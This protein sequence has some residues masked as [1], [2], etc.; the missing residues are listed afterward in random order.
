MTNFSLKNPYTII[1]LSLLVA[2]LGIMAFFRTPTDLFPNSTPPQVVV[3]TVQ[4]GA[5]AANISHKTTEV[6]EKELNSI[7]GLKKIV[8]TSRDEVSVVNAEFY[9]YKPIGEAVVDVQNAVSRIESKLPVNIK[10]PSIYRITDTT[11]PLLTIALTPKK[12]SSKNLRDIRLLAENQ[13]MK[14]LLQIPGV[15]DVDIFGAN[16][17]EINICIKKSVLDANNLSIA[18]V[19]GVL[20]QYNIN[21]PSGNVYTTKNE[22]IVNSYDEFKNLKEIENIP[23]I[24]K[25]DGT[26]FLRDI[27]EVKLATVEA[28]S[29][30]HGNGKTAIAITVMRLSTV[31][32]VSTIKRVKKNLKALKKKY[33]DIDFAITTDQS[34]VIDAN[35]RGMRSSLLQAILLTALVIFIF[36]A[37][38]RA[39]IVISISIPMAFLASLMILW[40]SPFTLNMVTLSGLIISVGMVVDASIVVLEN[41]FRHYREMKTPD[42]VIA[43]KNGVNEVKLSITAGMLTTVIVLM[44]VM[45]T[46]GYTQQLMRPLNLMICSTLVAA[47]LAALTIVP[48]LIAK[49]LAKPKHKKNFLERIFSYTDVGIACLSDTYTWILTKAL[50][51]RFVT[52]GIAIAIFVISMKIVPPLIGKEMM[53]PMDTGISI[54]SFN[55]QSDMN[56]KEVEKIVKRVEK[57]IYQNKSV[58]QVSTIVG[59]EPG[60]ISFG[61]GGR[62]SQSV[63]I[64]TRMIPRNKR[65][66][67]IWEVDGKWRKE[68]A[69]IAGI[70][71]LAITEYGATPLSTTKAPLDIIISGPGSEIL[72][73]LADEVI[74]RLKTIPGLIDIRRSWYKDKT[75]YRIKPN[76]LQCAMFGVTPMEIAKEVKSTLKGNVVGSFNLED[77]L[78]IPIRVKYADAALDS[79]QKLDDIYIPSKH[80]FIQLR[81][82]AQTE[83]I[84]VQP[85]ITREDQLNTIDITGLNRIYTIGQ[86]AAMAQK[87][88]TDIKLPTGYTLQVAGSMADMKASNDRMVK[89]L[90]IGL[91]LLYM[92]LLAIFKSFVHPVTIMAA[93]PLAVAGAMWGLLLFDKPMCKP[94]MMGIIFLG[95]T[96]VNNSILLLDFIIQARKNGI[97]KNEAI[98][99]SVKLRIRPI[100]M[101]TVSTIVGLMPLIFEMAVGLERMSPLGIVAA[102]GLTAGTLLTLVIIPVVYSLMDDL[103]S[104]VTGKKH[105]IAFSHTR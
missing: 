44:P 58:L 15:A 85:Y 81:N 79:P 93:I 90:L 99:N 95:G 100:L 77:Y 25:N 20:T 59:A 74:E 104:I 96:I 7:S 48:L 57:I 65:K 52:L 84:K 38:M 17:P 46:G 54:I 78:S 69:Q 47:L 23:I 27:A 75:Q 41:I 10:K 16:Q 33:P 26:L 3:I 42:A 5:S 6:I 28:R 34:P 14:S 102:F 88:L 40:L 21:Y 24:N 91:V 83:K 80:G 31:G 9:Y 71:D 94:A 97:E 39:A 45:F 98:I 73:S 68:L 82:I 87:K 36:M 49:L 67:T 63:Q 19:I 35:I 13:I 22:Y 103:S 101:T 29:F 12:K 32:T 72:S 60:Q 30:Y 55:T 50:K 2:I 76:H 62:T 105:K 86:V 89:A 56:L 11:K 43:T 1:A 66:E 53:P 92:L 4:P 8:S 70:R 37:D 64:T 51:H 61:G 18:Y